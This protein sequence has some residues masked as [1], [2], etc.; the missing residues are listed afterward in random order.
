MRSACA[1]RCLPLQSAR[2]DRLLALGPAPDR[3]LPADARGDAL[4]RAALVRVR[5]PPHGLRAADDH[6]PTIPFVA[7]LEGGADVSFACPA[8][9][10]RPGW[11]WRSECDEGVSKTCVNAQF[12]S[13]LP[14]CRRQRLILRCDR[15]SR[16]STSTA[17]VQQSQRRESSALLA[18]V[19][20]PAGIFVARPSAAANSSCSTRALRLIIL[21][22]IVTRL[23][24]SRPSRATHETMISLRSLTRFLKSPS[25]IQKRIKQQ[26]STPL[27]CSARQFLPG[28][29]FHRLRV[30]IEMGQEWTCQKWNL[31]FPNGKLLSMSIPSDARISP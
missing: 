4:A 5:D 19:C 22:R 26:H 1:R 7:P 2:C 16:L 17:S 18:C 27:Y 11:P 23:L 12:D 31:I 21:A 3:W 28:R 9:A 10:P 6:A 30:P 20:R 24:S 13:M 14:L 15:G 8:P 25:E 29:R